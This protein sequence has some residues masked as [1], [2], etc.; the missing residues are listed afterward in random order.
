VSSPDEA[1]YSMGTVIGWRTK[2][3]LVEYF[4]PSSEVTNVLEKEENV[5]TV[6]LDNGG[7][8][9]SNAMDLL[10][11]MIRA[12]K[13]RD[14][15]PGYVE[16]DSPL[17]QYR[18]KIGRFC[19]RAA[20]APDAASPFAFSKLILKREQEL[21][22]SLKSRS[23][24]NNWGGKDGIRNSWI[25][26]MKENFDSMNVLRDGLLS[27]EDAF[28]E[29]CGGQ[30]Q[31]ESNE[32]TTP[33]RSASEILEN[34]DLR[35]DVELESYGMKPKG[36]WNSYES[37]AVFREIVSSCTSLGIL[38]LGLDLICRN[39]QAYLDSTKSTSTRK[40]LSNYEQ[41]FYS[42][43]A[44]STRSAYATFNEDYSSSSRRTQ[45]QSYASFF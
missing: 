43:S 42:T 6:S 31:E 21:Y 40:A 32:D 9:E 29:M 11:S 36:L 37:R 24:D 45:P 14:Q 23:H 44:R 7:E 17:F 10:N 8:L 25:I 5:W 39:A 27:L 16:H 18:N 22:A 13:W 15:H 26:S 12:K 35:F 20:D 3:S 4:E 38:S 2:K 19:G 28:F 33:H 34:D 41:G 1:T 30:E